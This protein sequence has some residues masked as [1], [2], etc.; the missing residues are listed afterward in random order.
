MLGGV[1][2]GSVINCES[3]KFGLNSLDDC[4]VKLLFLLRSFEAGLSVS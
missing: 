4:W 3:P 1:S 2:R